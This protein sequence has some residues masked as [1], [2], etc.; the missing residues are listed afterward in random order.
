MGVPILLLISRNRDFRLE[1]LSSLE[2][3][4]R[5]ETAP[6]EQECGRLW[7]WGCYGFVINIKI[8]RS[9]V[10]AVTAVTALA[11]T[12]G[13]RRQKQYKHERYAEKRLT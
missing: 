5:G 11:T 6:K 2:D 12:R 1:N 3:R 10:N 9:V 13:Q 4:K 8:N 7:D